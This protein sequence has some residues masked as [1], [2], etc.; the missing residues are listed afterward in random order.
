MHAGGLEGSI[1]GT[2]SRARSSVL[3]RVPGRVRMRL[4]RGAWRCQLHERVRGKRTTRVSGVGITRD[5]R[6]F[7]SDGHAYYPHH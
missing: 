6:S 5:M 3:R 1:R 2:H 7:Q 4:S